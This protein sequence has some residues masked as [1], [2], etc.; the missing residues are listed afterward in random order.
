MQVPLSLA[1]ALVKFFNLARIVVVTSPEQNDDAQLL[2]VK[3]TSSR[4][5]IDF[6]EVHNSAELDILAGSVVLDNFGI[7]KELHE[8]KMFKD[9]MIWLLFSD[10]FDRSE[11]PQKLQLDSNF[12]VAEGH[13]GTFDLVEWYRV[14]GHLLSTDFGTWSVDQG[15]VVPIPF[16]WK[17]RENLQG[18]A[19][20]VGSSFQPNA[21]MK[22]LRDGHE[23]YVGF[24]PE[25]VEAMQQACNFSIDWVFE[26]IAGVKDRNGSWNGLVGMLHKQE[27]DFVASSLAVTLERSEVVTYLP[28][29]GYNV[30]TL[31]ILDPSYHGSEGE[32]NIG[33][34][35]D[36]FSPLAW[37]V[38]LTFS[39]LSL[40]FLI[41]WSISNNQFRK[42]DILHLI[43]LC[44]CEMTSKYVQTKSPMSF[45]KN[46][47]YFSVTV[48]VIVAM[49]YYE[50]MLTSFLT[51]RQK[52]P[53]IRSFK[54]VLDFGYKV[55]VE[56]GTAHAMELEYSPLGSGKREVFDTLIKDNPGAY[57][58]TE[59][60]IAELML[61]NP[62]IVTYNHQYSFAWD[63]RLTP[64]LGLDD[65]AKIHV[66]LAVTLGSELNGLFQYQ[67][68]KAFQ[69]G[70]LSFLLR[71]WHPIDNRA[72]QDTCGIKVEDLVS[73]GPLGFKSLLFPEVV[74][75]VGILLSVTTFIVEATLKIFLRKKE[76]TVI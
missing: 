24:Y 46:L 39:I 50:S 71:K 73:A 51:A 68:I 26:H 47:L 23:T 63:K 70:V 53:R 56:T 4:A 58:H 74:L 8:E 36:V 57:Y 6:L 37:I 75:A 7:F 35:V 65:R 25:I 20:T 42:T 18:V 16:K 33:A 44:L 67:I 30:L 29:L 31:I 72:P 64:L 38:V 49:S 21:N 2:E 59:K 17:R 3:E 11:A 27:V 41:F 34:F 60:D 54:D 62:K 43:L 1:V 61:E 9:D 52:P 13:D 48:F 69:S 28:A 55:M 66:A 19:L 10:Q 22:V 12:I 76:R 45:F 5:S 32:I 15:L 40:C 14:S